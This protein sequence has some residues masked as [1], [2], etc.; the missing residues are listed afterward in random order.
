[1]DAG[2]SK[3]KNLLLERHAIQSAA[4]INSFLFSSPGS[5]TLPSSSYRRGGKTEEL[6]FYI[7]ILK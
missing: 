7:Y 4:E 2:T 1:M 6:D 3:K 5:F